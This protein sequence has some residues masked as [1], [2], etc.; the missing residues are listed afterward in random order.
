[1]SARIAGVLRTARNLLAALLLAALLHPAAA[2]AEACS[3]GATTIPECERQVQ[4]AHSYSGWE[5]KGWAYYCTG[6]H[7]YYWGAS[8]YILG[9]YSS[10]NSC[11]SVAENVFAENQANKFDATITNWC[12]K[13]ESITITL[14]CSKQPPPGFPATCN[15]TGSPVSDPGCKTTN[16]TNHCSSSNPPVCF[17]TSSET[18]DDGTSY[19]C[20]TDLAVTWC[21]KC[22]S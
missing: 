11:F 8:S 7:P 4:A 19:S 5:T 6:D 1:M 22:G 2:L 17:Q 16:I 3:G 18:C 10:N 9:N 12:L 13:S 20:T 21:F 15:I 14:G